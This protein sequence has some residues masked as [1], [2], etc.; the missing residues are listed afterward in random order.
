MIK[1]YGEDAL[2]LVNS[3]SVNIPSKLL[4]GPPFANPCNIP[5]RVDDLDD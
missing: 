1:H 3:L 2:P 5:V 4:T